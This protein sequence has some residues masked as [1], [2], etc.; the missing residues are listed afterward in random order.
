MTDMIGRIAALSAAVECREQRVAQLPVGTADKR[1]D[2]TFAA[3]EMMQD[4]RMGNAHVARDILQAQALRPLP[5]EAFLG[6]IENQASRLLGGTPNPL[7]S[8]P[9]RNLA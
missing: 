4:S 6:G 1:P 5:G 7:G 3:F 2:E 9:W 8:G